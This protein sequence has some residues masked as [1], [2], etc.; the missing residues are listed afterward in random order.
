MLLALVLIPSPSA[1]AAT[2]DGC[3]IPNGGDVDGNGI[4]D[5]G[6]Q[7]ICTYTSVYAYD[8]SGDYY[9]DLGDGRIQG[10]VNS[11][12]ELDQITLS[13]CDYQVQTKGSFEND[14][15]Q[16]SD[17]ISNMI[18]CYGY[19]GNAT[20]NYQ[21]VHQDDPR[22][23]GNPDWSIWGSWEYHLSTQSGAG[24]LVRVPPTGNVAP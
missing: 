14:P 4:G 20:Y 21:I 7:V 9:W 12:D 19:D 1:S 17:V 5:D 15:F 16:D 11:I 2:G 23:T 10:T 22:Y 13:V 6:V 8:A 24:N 3:N 18:H